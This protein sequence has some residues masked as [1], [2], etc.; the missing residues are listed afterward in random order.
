MEIALWIV[1][2]IVALLYLAAGGMKTFA[3]AKYAASA[4]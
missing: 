4:A 2:S 3:T 1:A